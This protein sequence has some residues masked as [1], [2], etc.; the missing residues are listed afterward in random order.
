[1][2]SSQPRISPQPEVLTLFSRGQITLPA[3]M[4][5]HQSITAGDALIVEEVHGD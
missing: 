5:K 4:L 2:K 1:M 3:G